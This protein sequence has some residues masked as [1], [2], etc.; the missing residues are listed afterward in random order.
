M[1]SVVTI[2]KTIMQLVKKE[3]LEVSGYQIYMGRNS[4]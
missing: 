4:I 3:K 1:R 2:C